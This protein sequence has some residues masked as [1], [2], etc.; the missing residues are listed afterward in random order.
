MQIYSSTKQDNITFEMKNN[1]K[2]ADFFVAAGILLPFG[3]GQGTGQA[4]N[5]GGIFEN[6]FGFVGGKTLETN[7]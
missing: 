4:L 2:S 5:Y 6:D 3:Y 1:K 7:K